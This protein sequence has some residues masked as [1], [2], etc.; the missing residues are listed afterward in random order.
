M[1]RILTFT[2][3]ACGAGAMLGVAV[4]AQSPTPTPAESPS[5]TPGQGGQWAGH[6][7]GKHGVVMAHLTNSLGLSGSQQAAIAPIIQAARPQMKAIQEDARAKRKAL[8]ESVSAQISPLLTPEQQAKFTR[9]VQ[10]I[11]NGPVGGG[12]QEPQHLKRLG[13]ADAGG[14]PG[15]KGEVL[16]RLTTQLGLTADQQNQMKPILD[17]A[18]AQV[19]AVRQNT[20]LTSEQ[21][22]AQIKEA[23]QAAHNQING[24]LTPTQQKQLESL[25]MN[26]RHGQGRPSA[27]P[28][29]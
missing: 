21:K 16:Q 9:M 19:L 12:A 23:M 24:I 26:Y 5:W 29:P 18:H 7:Q 14:S 11:E 4:Q 13:G 1:K 8:I 3:I 6:K 27:S 28:S 17:A 2:L 20:T 25:R 15:A 10:R 22:F